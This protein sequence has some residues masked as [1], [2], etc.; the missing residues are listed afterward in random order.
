MANI[1]M[2]LRLRKKEAVEAVDIAARIDM[3]VKAA[4]EI[5]GPDPSVARMKKLGGFTKI[6]KNVL[7]DGPTAE[8]NKLGIPTNDEWYIHWYLRNQ[9]QNI[10]HLIQEKVRPTYVV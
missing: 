6:I 4:V 5:I 9:M 3:V 7:G 2:A 8:S 10:R 1:A